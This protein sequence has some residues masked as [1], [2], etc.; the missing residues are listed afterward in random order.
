MASSRI[1]SPLDSISIVTRPVF[2]SRLIEVTWPTLT[3]ATRTG[4][5]GL[6][7]WAEAN[8]AWIV[9]PCLNGIFLVKPKY[10]TIASATIRIT[11]ART[12]FARESS[13]TGI[14]SWRR[15]KEFHFFFPFE[16][17]ASPRSCSV[18]SVYFSP[19]RFC[20]RLREFAD[21]GHVRR[22]QVPDRRL[23][24]DVGLVPGFA[25]RGWPGPAVFGYMFACR[26]L[27]CVSSITW[28]MA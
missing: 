26:W 28:V 24:G 8:S 7:F 10:T 13:T 6:M 23:G 14:S 12:G 18:G 9:Y 17:G 16:L 20:S 19:Y 15:Q 11:P 2:P 4:D 1:G 21:L 22:R 27:L 25:D 5:F 3:P